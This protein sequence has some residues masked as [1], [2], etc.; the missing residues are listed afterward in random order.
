MTP[1]RATI[2]R[3]AVLGSPITH[4]LSP[5]LHTAAYAELGLTGWHYEAYEVAAD[6]LAGFLAGCD[7]SWRG[8]SLT[9]PLKVAALRLGTPT[10]VV[11]Q[12]GAANTLIFDREGHRALHNT[13]VDGVVWA[14][15]RAGIER[16]ERVSLLGAG[17]TARSVMAGL[18]RL[19][20]R[21]LTVLARHP[22]RAAGLAGL[23]AE[24]GVRLQV[25]DWA[26]SPPTGDLLVATTTAG[27]ADDRAEALAAT[28]AAVLDVV[29][30]PWPTPLAVAAA[31]SGRTVV[32]GLD[33][34]VGQALGQIELMTGRSVTADVLYAAGRAALSARI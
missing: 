9:M 8:L 4:S 3:C 1:E 24:L 32:S 17:A 29:Y 7:R 34:L 2:H 10:A 30:D 26:E 20:T 14:L 31:G 11:T 19:G 22:A 13:D 12:I 16:V 25:R 18:A 15:A 5:A 27:A 23:A 21:E 28:A 33:L 6:G